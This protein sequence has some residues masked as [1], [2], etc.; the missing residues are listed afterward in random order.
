[1]AN[2]SS[3]EIANFTTASRLYRYSISLSTAQIGNRESIF[4]LRYR[5]AKVVDPERVGYHARAMVWTAIQSG[6]LESAA[7]FLEALDPVAES[8]TYFDFF[9]PIAFLISVK[10][11]A[12]ALDL[13]QHPPKSE[14]RE[15]RIGRVLSVVALDRC[16]KLDAAIKEADLLLE[17]STIA[18]EQALLAAVKVGSLTHLDQTTEAQKFFNHFRDVP[19]DA[20]T[21]GY[22]LR[23]G[24]AAFPSSEACSI[25]KAAMEHFSSIGDQYGLLTCRNNFGSYLC[26]L[27][28]FEEAEPHYQAAADG[29]GEFGLPHVEEALCNL[30]LVDLLTGRFDKAVARLE[31]LLEI[32][33]S[34][35][36]R[37]YALHHL[38]IARLCL[39]QKEAAALLVPE[40]DA[41]ATKIE[42]PT[43]RR[44]HQAN[45]LLILRAIEDNSK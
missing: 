39:R 45:C 7:R 5:L 32:A 44:R 20:G 13:L 8:K 4:T 36:P 3:D 34:N 24:A 28:R 43:A 19:R 6:S 25:V 10:R 22:F 38:A 30:G 12:E 18:E 14:W 21:Y 26:G 27:G 9:V 33:S 42:V 11:Y 41:L 23:N 15:F 17:D 40:A 29:L 1:M 31:Q 37:L 2:I 16:R 35:V